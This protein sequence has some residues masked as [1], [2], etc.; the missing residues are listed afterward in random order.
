MKKLLYPTSMI[1][2]A[3][4]V[5][6]SCQPKVDVEKEKVAVKDV[7][8]NE[9]DAYL[10][11]DFEKLYSLYI[12]DD[13]NTRLQETCS[14]EHPIYS[15][16]NNVRT[17]LEDMAK[18]DNPENKNVKCLKDGFIIKIRDNCAWVI[19]KDNWTWENNGVPGSIVG[20]QTTFMEKIGGNWKI[21][22]MSCFYRD[23]S[24]SE[25][26]DSIVVK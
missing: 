11:K 10:A 25:L 7:I 4:I 19:N 2:G 6:I 13:L 8:Q 22:M 1:M 20:I 14:K 3:F 18:H 23:Q 21:A 16:W 5:L 24:N 26:K 17:F 15:G 9:V 12:Q